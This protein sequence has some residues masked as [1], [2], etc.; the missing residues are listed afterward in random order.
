MIPYKDDNPT[1]RPPYVTVSIIVLN[2]IVFI[3]ELAYP[4]GLERFALNYGAVPY[5]LL[6]MNVV[7]PIG[8]VTSIFTSMFTHGGV[9]QPGQ[10]TNLSNAI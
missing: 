2:F 10:S 4:G 5:R 6:S 7:Q 3:Y 1:S 9:L 8:P